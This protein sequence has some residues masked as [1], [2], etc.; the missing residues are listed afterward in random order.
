MHYKRAELHSEQ[1]RI[2]AH[3]FELFL[4]VFPQ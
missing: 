1:Y 4:N 2:L 3:T